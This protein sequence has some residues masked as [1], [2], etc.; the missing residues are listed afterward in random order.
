MTGLTI[1]RTQYTFMDSICYVDTFTVG[2]SKS[3][4]TSERE[5]EGDEQDDQGEQQ[6]QEQEE[7][8]EEQ[9]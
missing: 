2:A 7:E 5:Q 3:S 4:P 8:Q 1:I 6:E 9:G